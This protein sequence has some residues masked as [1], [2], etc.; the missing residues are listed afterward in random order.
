VKSALLPSSGL[1]G[2]VGRRAA[3]TAIVTAIVTA[4]TARD[5]E[6]VHDRRHDA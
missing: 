1:A 6:D 5:A 2:V 3:F 4:F